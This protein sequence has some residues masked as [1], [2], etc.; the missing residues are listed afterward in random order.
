M[1]E[2]LQES[3]STYNPSS[4]V[5][6]CFG[7]SSSQVHMSNRSQHGAQDRRRRSYQMTTLPLSAPFDMREH[8]SKLLTL[9]LRPITATPQRKPN[10]A[11]CVHNIFTV[12]SQSLCPEVR[13]WTKINSYQSIQERCCLSIWPLWKRP[14]DTQ[15]ISL[16]PA[17]NSQ[18]GG[19]QHSPAE[20]HG[21][22]LGGADSGPCSFT[23]GWELSQWAGGPVVTT[24]PGPHH[25][26]RAQMKSWGCSTKAY[27]WETSH[28]PA[29]CSTSDVTDVTT[30]VVTRTPCYKACRSLQ[31][32]SDSQCYHSNHRD[33]LAMV[34]ERHQ[35]NN[36][37]ETEALFISLQQNSY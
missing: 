1:D 28:S 25:L 22:R 32:N 11:A 27:W 19:V 15:T 7:A 23:L 4:E 24:L 35:R 2:W 13:V 33:P 17:K 6:V 5:W 37:S 36:L 16:E 30:G 31:G 26:Q 29:V 14:L 12:T 3:Q 8:L 20:K 21:F 34:F 10:S 18:P 9:F